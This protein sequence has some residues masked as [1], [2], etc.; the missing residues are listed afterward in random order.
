MDRRFQR[1]TQVSDAVF[2]PGLVPTGFG[3]VARF[4]TE[5]EYARRRF[6]EA[7]EVLGYSL[8]DAYR[9]A[10]I[11]DWEVFQSAFLAL[12]L[13][14]ADWAECHE[15]MSPA[16]CGGQSFGGI[17]SA[18]YCGS[19]SYADA[20]RLVRASS[21]VE[22]DYFESLAEPVG[23]YFFTNIPRE[24]VI[25]LVDEF[26]DA[27]EWI[28]ISV[29]MDSDIF[30]VSAQMRTIEK[31]KARTRE[32]GGF[33]FYTMN[34]AEHC[35]GVADLRER[36]YREVYSR[37]TWRS[38]RVPIL[39]DVDGRLIDDPE[40]IMQDLLDGW[41][42]PVRWSTMI[43]G[44]RRAGTTRVYVI[45]PRMIFSRAT[46]DVFPTLA[47]TPKHALAAGVGSATGAD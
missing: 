3:P 18:V 12:T 43:E 32:L 30:A 41:V 21:Q 24:K 40:S 6:A 11:H 29:E 36:L 35:A 23:C 9:D 39:S 1:E 42:Y 25:R 4:V 26:R 16:V 8:A 22:Q 10:S 15:G 34:R 28:E 31:F 13:A 27:G 17:V 14:L 20:L 45:G 38:P 2:F 47:I 37:F 33:S 7:D 46:R 5:S 44:L 19:L